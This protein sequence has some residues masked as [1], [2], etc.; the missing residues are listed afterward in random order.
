[1]IFPYAFRHIDVL[2]FTENA[3][4]LYQL[5]YDECIAALP[6]SFFTVFKLPKSYFEIKFRS[7]NFP[8]A[9][10]FTR[11]SYSFMLSSNVLVMMMM[12][13]DSFLNASIL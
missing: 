10:L 4:V 5:P 1:M 6:P 12:M 8:Q 11:P 3:M 9:Q 2:R 13:I 7:L